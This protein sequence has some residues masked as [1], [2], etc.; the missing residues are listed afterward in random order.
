MSRSL[1]M[2]TSVLGD[3]A[4][5]GRLGYITSQTRRP[6]PRVATVNVPDAPGQPR[7]AVHPARSPLQ[8][9]PLSSQRRAPI[10]RHAGDLDSPETC[11]R[12]SW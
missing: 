9:G 7:F 10:V 1:A 3:V 6:T 2:T 11:V 12:C 5:L 4:V 8:P